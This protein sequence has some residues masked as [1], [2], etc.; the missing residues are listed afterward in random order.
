MKNEL[1]LG[2][3]INNYN[4]VIGI[5]KYLICEGLSFSGIVFIEDPKPI[6]LTED[7][8]LKCGFEKVKDI[9]QDYSYVLNLKARLK[10]IYYLGDLNCASIFQD[11]KLIDLAHGIVCNLHSLQNLIHSLTNEELNIEL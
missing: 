6:P 11:G 3:Y 7:I 1:R 8:L 2:N 4:K 10:I 5:S 9:Q